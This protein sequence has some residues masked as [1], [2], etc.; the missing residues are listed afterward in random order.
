MGDHGTYAGWSRH[1]REGTE[2]CADCKQAKA[3][4]QKDWRARG[5]DAVRT[6][7]RRQQASEK[8][9]RA[10]AHLYPADYQRLYSAEIA[11][12]EEAS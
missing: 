7:R 11:K 6:E 1:K 10:L 4:Y 3:A 2:P 5:G 12:L 8:A 9:R